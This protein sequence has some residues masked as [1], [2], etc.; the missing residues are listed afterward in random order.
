M[1]NPRRVANITEYSLAARRLHAY[2]WEYRKRKEAPELGILFQLCDGVLQRFYW[3]A[4]GNEFPDEL[5]GF[6]PFVFLFGFL[7]QALVQLFHASRFA[8]G[9]AQLG[10]LCGELLSKSGYILLD[11]LDCGCGFGN[12][13]FQ[14]GDAFRYI[15]GARFRAGLRF[16]FTALGTSHSRSRFQYIHAHFYN[17]RFNIFLNRHAEKYIYL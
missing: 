7:L 15:F 17:G 4:A 1:Q 14:I 10:L 6:H 2:F 13:I 9:R 16:I 12:S 5:F 8:F 3:F 11:L